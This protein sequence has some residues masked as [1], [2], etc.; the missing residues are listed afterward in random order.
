MTSYLSMS[1]VPISLFSND[2]SKPTL[3]TFKP[4]TKFFFIT[5]KNGI[6]ELP[7]IARGTFYLPKKFR[8]EAF[9]CSRKDCELSVEADFVKKKVTKSISKKSVI[10]YS[11]MLKALD[12]HLV[13]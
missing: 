3:P 7:L 10:A 5:L 2:F 9:I 11:D 6:V 4:G 1:F 13:R 8:D 12:Y